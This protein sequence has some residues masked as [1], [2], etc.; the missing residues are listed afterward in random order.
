MKR[1]MHSQKHDTREDANPIH[2][3]TNVHSCI[4]YIFCHP[5][6]IVCVSCCDVGH[7]GQNCLWHTNELILTPDTGVAGTLAR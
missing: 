3:F 4:T 6:H 5:E 7:S 1:W 2:R